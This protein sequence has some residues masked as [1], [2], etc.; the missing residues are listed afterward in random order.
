MERR[1]LLAVA[2]S[3]LCIFLYQE[4][5]LR[6]YAPPREPTVSE[7]ATRETPPSPVAGPAEP[8]IP[9]AAEEPPARDPVPAGR[10]IVVETDLFT[11]ELTTSGG[12][13]AS[14]RLK[15][16]RSA[17]SPASPPLELVNTAPGQDLPLG[18]EI[19]PLGFDD[20]TV[21][22]QTDTDGLLLTGGR[23][24]SVLFR[25]VRD[26]IEI[27][28]ELRFQGD[29][30]PVELVIRPRTT[31]VLPP[32]VIVTLTHSADV[33]SRYAFR[34]VI[35]LDGRTLTEVTF[36]GLSEA[37]KAMQAPR[38][39]GF[40]DPYF[41]SAIVPLAPS[42]GPLLA[43]RGHGGAE[44]RMTIPLAGVPPEAAAL[45]YFGPK[46]V[47]ALD[48]AGH[49]LTRAVDFGWFWF[50]AVPLLRLLKAFNRVTGNYGIDIILL[51]VLIKILFIPL[52]Q[53]SL[54]S[55]REMQKLQPQ[56]AKIRERFKSDPQAQQREMMELYKRHR[57]NPLSGCLPMVLQVPVFVGLYNALLKAIELRHAAF[58]LWITDLSSPDRLVV[59]G[60]GLPVL[61]IAMGGSMFLQQWM[62]PAA[63]DPM[64]QRMML[65][66]PIIF[67][68]MFIN[69]PSGLVLYWLVNNL[70]TVAQ[71]YYLVNRPAK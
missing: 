24:G 54:L 51:T 45:L 3:L 56:M 36:D 50:V 62:T 20:R 39:G 27:D 43:Q 10:G 4:L 44:T 16:Y 37:P 5:V 67:T 31:R 46:D 2:L 11:A 71:Q 42:A 1:V 7:Q 6:R 38:W 25:S 26:G 28:K 17:V 47:D 60:V 55:M 49:D 53:K 52:T 32:S 29:A 13:L 58:A 14:L 68:F 69:F 41:L 65:F 30:Y 34:G 8:G 66:M 35:A 21:V 57:I 48:A 63:G 18:I 40:G 59:A 33:A 22:Y 61:T 15:H 19:A 12:R 64:Q 23:T 70:L 9:G